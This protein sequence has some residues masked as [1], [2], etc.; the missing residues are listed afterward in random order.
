M[1]RGLILC[2]LLLMLGLSGCG[3]DNTLTIGV[4]SGSY[5][6]TPNG[7]C[8]AILNDAI[9]RFREQHPNVTVEYVSGITPDG[10]SEWFELVIL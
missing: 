5:W 7:D 8:Y 6:D 9:A 1:K 4:Y 3:K 10:Y 2:V